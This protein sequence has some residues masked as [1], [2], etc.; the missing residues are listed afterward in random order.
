MI[1]AAQ[2]Y[3]FAAYYHGQ[4]SKLSERSLLFLIQGPPSLQHI[5]LTMHSK[6][7]RRDSPDEARTLYVENIQT[8]DVIYKRDT[9][10]GSDPAR[11]YLSERAGIFDWK[12]TRTVRT[13]ILRFC[14][15]HAQIYNEQNAKPIAES[16]QYAAQLASE[17]GISIDELYKEYITGYRPEKLTGKVLRDKIM[18]RLEIKEADPPGPKRTGNERQLLGWSLSTDFLKDLITWRR[19]MKRS[20]GIEALDKLP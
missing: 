3:G 15:Y 9:A 20:R 12:R 18:Q 6:Y 1:R 19:E 8:E 14:K 13:M 5:L 10:D 17:L 7:R 16:E 11:R 4:L 2:F